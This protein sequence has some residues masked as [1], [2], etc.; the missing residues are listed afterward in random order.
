[1]KDVLYF[2]FSPSMTIQR[3]TVAVRTDGESRLLVLVLQ[4]LG[5]TVAGV[6]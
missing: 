3:I 1:M 4:R 6:Y 5:V 2:P